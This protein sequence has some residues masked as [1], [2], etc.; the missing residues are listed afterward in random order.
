MKYIYMVK[1]LWYVGFLKMSF[2][3]KKSIYIC[4]CIYLKKV[5]LVVGFLT[6]FPSNYQCMWYDILSYWT[7]SWLILTS[8]LIYNIFLAICDFTWEFKHDPVCPLKK[9]NLTEIWLKNLDLFKIGCWCQRIKLFKMKKIYLLHIINKQ[10]KPT[11]R[12]G[13]ELH[14]SCLSGCQQIFLWHF[15]LWNLLTHR[16]SSF[17]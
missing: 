4:G 14:A 7:T 2:K 17:W 16:K 13:S 15:S 10:F 12:M 1:I 9:M 8:R 6:K 11:V 5:L 3:N